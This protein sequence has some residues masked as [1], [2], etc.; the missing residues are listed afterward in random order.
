MA[1]QSQ[2]IE[3]LSSENRDVKVVVLDPNGHRGVQHEAQCDAD[4]HLLR[5][6]IFFVSSIQ[7]ARD[8]IKSK[9]PQLVIFPSNVEGMDFVSLQS[10]F[11]NSHSKAKLVPLV[12]N[13]SLAQY[14]ESKRIGGVLDFGDPNVLSSFDAIRDFLVHCIRELSKAEKNLD[15]EFDEVLRLQK[16]MFLKDSGGIENKERSARIC[17]LILEKFDLSS[18]QIARTLLAECLFKPDLEFAQY[19]AILAGR[20][21]LGILDIL[22][23]TASWEHS[24]T[25]PASVS[26]FSITASNILA[27]WIGQG[28]ESSAILQK[29]KERPHFLH[30]VSIRAIN[31][32]VVQSCISCVQ[33]LLGAK[34][35]G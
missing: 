25:K 1:E 16:A 14:R 23:E 28:M 34:K 21:E 33:D 4:E 12:E 7:T 6:S 31:E 2:A 35:V 3:I 10:E 20:E 30:H 29:I 26:G 24:G 22:K 8:T 11:R 32:N 18:S 27:Q 17:G 5:A 13:P 19:E 15:G 9:R